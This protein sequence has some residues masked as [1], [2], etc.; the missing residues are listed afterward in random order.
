MLD[1]KKFQP[2]EMYTGVDTP[3]DQKLLEGIVNSAIKD[4]SAFPE[5]LD[6][7]SVRARLTKMIDDADNYATEDREQ[8][9]RYAVRIWRAA[10]FSEESRLFPVSDEKVLAIP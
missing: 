2:T 5:P 4:V 9:Y 8:V 7:R 3:E 6:K 10:G 1:E